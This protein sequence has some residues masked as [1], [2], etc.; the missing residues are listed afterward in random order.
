MSAKWESVQVTMD[1][2]MRECLASRGVGCRSLT[3]CGRRA[4]PRTF[5]MPC[6]DLHGWPWNLPC[7][8]PSPHLC[9]CCDPCVVPSI[10]LNPFQGAALTRSV[11]K[12]LSDSSNLPGPF[13]HNSLSASRHLEGT[14][15]SCRSRHKGAGENDLTKGNNGALLHLAVTPGNHWDSSSHSSIPLASRIKFTLSSN[16]FQAS[17][18]ATSDLPYVT[19]AS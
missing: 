6:D 7:S 15:K 4:I 8:F 2:Q 19:G 5:Y 12:V 11:P 17:I 16:T 9:A 3:S 13:L 18:A 1:T 14:W 10:H